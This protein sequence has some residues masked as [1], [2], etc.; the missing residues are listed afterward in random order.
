[1]AD[2]GA[3]VKFK[4]S[5]RALAD[6]AAWVAQAVQKKPTTPVMAG[7]RIVAEADQVSVYGFNYESAHTAVLDAVVSTPGEC[8]VSAKFATTILAALE[9][10]DVEVTLEDHRLSMKAGR[11]TYRAS[12]FPPGDFP[13]LPSMPDTVVGRVEHGHLADTLRIVDHAAAHNST[14]EAL[15]G[16]HLRT[17]DGTLWLEA[18]DGHRMARASL[19]HVVT[20]GAPD[21]AAVVPLAPLWAAL[22]GLSGPV[23]VAVSDGL[24]GLADGWRTVTTR[25]IDGD[26]PKVDGLFAAKYLHHLEV[27]TA[28]FAAAVKRTL[29]VT[30]NEAVGLITL[31]VDD[32]EITLSAVDTTGSDGVEKVECVPGPKFPDVFSVDFN[33]RYLGQTLDAISANRVQVRVTPVADSNALKPV[34][35]DPVDD[36]TC[37]FI[38]MPRRKL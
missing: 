38:I 7:L 4:T 1:M 32:G 27:D 10:Q 23:T 26:F 15:N 30:E 33:G 37:G 21:L 3:A 2:G 14:V 24:V 19:P 13:T 6:T 17:V 36:D 11:S 34:G 16:I 9:G 28:E 22:K 29:L 25:R 12:V 20:G 8:V 5:R 18:T 35:I 31:V